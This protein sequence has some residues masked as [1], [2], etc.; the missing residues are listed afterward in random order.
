[1]APDSELIEM[2]F[3]HVCEHHPEAVAELRDEE[4]LR[5]AGVA[6][7][8][9]KGHGFQ[10][11]ASVAA[12]AALMFLVGPNFDEQANIRAALRI[13]GLPADTCM[14][15]LMANTKEDDW[16]AAGAQRANWP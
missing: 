12:F 10:K 9:A 7:A 6:V 1:M 14:Q 15:R 8:R 16:E 4:I 3:E 11:E 13:P 2:V 5:R